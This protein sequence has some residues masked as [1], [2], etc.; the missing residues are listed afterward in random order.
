MVKKPEEVRM[1]KCRC[2]KLSERDG[3]ACV[4]NPIIDKICLYLWAEDGATTRTIELA[5]AVFCP[6]C[7]DRLTNCQ[8]TSFDVPH[9][10]LTHIFRED[11]QKEQPVDSP[12]HEFMEGAKPVVVEL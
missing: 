12:H 4:Y 7:G 3:R 8:D 2:G 11:V 6:V 9:Y 5:G 10:V 1:L